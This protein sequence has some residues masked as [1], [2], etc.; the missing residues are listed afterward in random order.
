MVTRVRDVMTSPAVV[1][2]PDASFMQAVGKLASTRLAALPVVDLD[3]R[4]LGV[5]SEADL[6]V[7]EERQQLEAEPLGFQGPR[8]RAA[9]S[10]AS[11]RAVAEVMTQVPIC[12]HPDAP[13]SAAAH[14]MRNQ[15][16]RRLPVV[17]SDNRVIGM[18]TRSDLLKVFLRTDEELAKEVRAFISYTLETVPS[19]VEVTVAGGRS[20]T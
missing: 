2:A 20:N 13:V 1:I 6:V 16:V 4:I 5:V 9:R 3:G 14:I 7:K 15:A 18:V 11:G 19:P 10:K 17:T 8:T 12:I